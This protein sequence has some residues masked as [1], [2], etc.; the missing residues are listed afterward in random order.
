MES[1]ELIEPYPL[2]EPAPT[3]NDRMNYA[4]TNDMDLNNPKTIDF[5]NGEN[6]EIVIETQTL[7]TPIELLKEVKINVASHMFPNIL[8][9]NLK[10]CKAY[11]NAIR[12][13]PN[14][15]NVPNIYTYRVNHLKADLIEVNKEIENNCKYLAKGQILFHGGL[16]PRSSVLKIGKVIKTNIP[17]STTLCPEVACVHSEYHKDGQV[18]VISVSKEKLARAY[19][20]RTTG[21]QRLK[22][23]FEILLE[24]GLDFQCTNIE[25][26]TT[27][28]TVYIDIV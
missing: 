20:F 14:L 6:T 18:W 24:K 23:E 19:I 13:C 15:N 17:I 4:I 16:W 27:T 8:H 21:N 22:H 12:A 10:N 9:N 5:I 26:D 28:T 2:V 3:Q 11:K 1:F 7:M 25:Y